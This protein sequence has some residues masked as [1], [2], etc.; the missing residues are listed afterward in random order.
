MVSWP[1]P[2]PPDSPFTLSNLPFGVFTTADDFEKRVGVAIGDS[3]I[4]LSVLEQPWLDV[5]FGR[6]KRT[7]K[8][9]LFR[10]GDLGKVASLPAASR[11]EL[12]ETLANW[13]QDPNSPLFRDASVFVAM[14]DAIMHLPFAIRSF[15]DFMCSDVHIA[16]CSRLA[17]APIPPSH[18]CMPLC[19]NGRASAVVVAGEPVHRPRGVVRDPLGSSSYSFQPSSMMDFE[20]EVGILVGRH[21]PAG[22]AITAAEAEDYI[23]GFVALNDWSARDIQFAEMAPLGPFNGKA[24]AT[25]I[26]PW[27]IM[28]EALASHRCC[29]T[30]VDLR[31][32]GLAGA[33]YLRHRHAESTWNLEVE[34]SVLRQTCRGTAPLLTSR[35]S[36]RDLRWSPGQML[37]HVASSGCGLDVGDLIGSGTISSPVS[38]TTLF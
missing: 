15:T 28:P 25:S 5:A 29:S 8:A 14:E 32:G 9:P 13:L 33:S 20:A 17:G 4:D 21:L 18:Y 7:C 1:I 38:V 10:G 30:A 24:F 36:M 27:V 23:F 22:R 31:D 2:I 34:V 3:I 26:S 12:R 37:A 35:S 6:L 11:T 16:N 19:Y